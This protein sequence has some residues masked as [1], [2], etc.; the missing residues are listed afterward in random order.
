MTIPGKQTRRS[1]ALDAANVGQFT[2]LC[3]QVVDS[4]ASADRDESDDWQL[5]KG[6]LTA[7]MKSTFHQVIHEAAALGQL[8][9]LKPVIVTNSNYDAEKQEPQEQPQTPYQESRR[10]IRRASSLVDGF[11]EESKKQKAKSWS[12]DN[13]ALDKLEQLEEAST[14]LSPLSTTTTPYE[15]LPSPV[16]PH[17]R[18]RFSG[19]TRHKLTE[20]LAQ[21]V[22]EGAHVRASR[23]QQEQQIKVRTS[24]H[25]VYCQR[26][27]PHQTLHYQQLRYHQVLTS[28]GTTAI[29]EFQDRPLPT[30]LIPTFVKAKR[31]RNLSQAALRKEVCQKVAAKAWERNFQLKKPGIAHRV[32]DRCLCVYCKVGASP[33]QTDKYKTLT[34]ESPFDEYKERKILQLATGDRYKGG[35]PAA[36]S[37]NNTGILYTYRYTWL[38]Q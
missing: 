32:T 11:V 2:R 7:A 6:S 21:G 34:L 19:M 5:K 37:A 10:R 23:L 20:C 33:A 28:S 26:P 30:P 3:E 13:S 29:I 1:V 9:R 14:I 8:K 38:A 12:A 27:S 4:I 35:V 16:V 24:C 15:A 18:K 31:D 36:L 22:A 25:C 17:F